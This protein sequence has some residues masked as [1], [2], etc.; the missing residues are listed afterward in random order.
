MNFWN[1]GV[2]YFRAVTAIYEITQLYLYVGVCEKSD[3]APFVIINIFI[4]N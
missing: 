1:I 4:S 3:V 2:W